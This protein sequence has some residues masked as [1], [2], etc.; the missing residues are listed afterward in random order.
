MKVLKWSGLFGRNWEILEF[1]AGQGDTKVLTH[2]EVVDAEV[3]TPVLY[4]RL[5]QIDYDGH[6]TY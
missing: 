2:Y 5:K 6:S 3:S 1:V 4:Y